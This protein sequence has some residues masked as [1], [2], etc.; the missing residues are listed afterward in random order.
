MVHKVVCKQP[1]RKSCKIGAHKSL[2]AAHRSNGKK[3]LRQRTKSGRATK[4]HFQKAGYEWKDSSNRWVKKKK[5]STKKNPAT[6]VSSTA[7]EPARRRQHQPNAEFTPDYLP[8][9]W[10]KRSPDRKKKVNCDKSTSG[11]RLNNRNGKC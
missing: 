10:D 2:L 1:P 6:K 9:D 3:F 4:L 8:A 7:L 11:G 5:A